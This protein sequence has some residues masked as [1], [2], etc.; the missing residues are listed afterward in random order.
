MGSSFGMF[1]LTNAL[2]VTEIQAL[3]ILADVEVKH[4]RRA[5]WAAARA[6]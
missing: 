3:K 2:V 1:L 5:A 4:V 6:R